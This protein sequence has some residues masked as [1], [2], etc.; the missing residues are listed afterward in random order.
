MSVWLNGVQV[1]RFLVDYYCK[2][3]THWVRKGSALFDAM[4][5]AICPKHHRKLRLSPHKKNH[6]DKNES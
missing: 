6:G 3:G 2:Q 5:S 1:S 4:G